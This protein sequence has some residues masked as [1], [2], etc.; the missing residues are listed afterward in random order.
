MELVRMGEFKEVKVKNEETGIE[1]DK[2]IYF[3]TKEID[4]IAI[5][6]TEKIQ[7][8][9]D[10]PDNYSSDDL[11][12]IGKKNLCGVSTELREKLLKLGI[13][14]I[15]K[16]FRE[17]FTPYQ[18]E[19]EESNLDSEE[20]NIDNDLPV[21]TPLSTPPSEDEEEIP[22]TPKEKKPDFKKLYYE[23]LEKVKKGEITLEN[24]DAITNSSLSEEKKQELYQLL[25]NQNNYQEQPIANYLLHILIGVIG[26]LLTAGFVKYLLLRKR[27]KQKEN[28][29]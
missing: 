24:K 19:E 12:K 20:D 15:N 9:L 28:K 5:K 21:D 29:L 17:T 14:K 2:D 1:E 23:L 18:N 26:I 4:F 25:I 11:L 8:I 7:N 16:E 6:N 22:I 13:E 10:N 3:I 27:N